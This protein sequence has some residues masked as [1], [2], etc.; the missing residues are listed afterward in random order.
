MGLGQKRKAATRPDLDFSPRSRQ[1]NAAD[2]QLASRAA[3]TL[4]PSAI[5]SV[6]FL[7]EQKS[8]GREGGR[9]RVAARGRDPQEPAVKVDSMNLLTQVKSSHDSSQIS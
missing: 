6:T 2:R 8:L 5:V 3:A 9:D 1:C 7:A 4:I